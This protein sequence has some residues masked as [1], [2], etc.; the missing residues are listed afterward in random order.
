MNWVFRK[1]G[2]FPTVKR[3]EYNGRIY[4][5]K[6]EAG[7]AR[8]LDFLKKAKEI[9][10]WIPQYKI[11][12][13][14]NGYHIANYYVDFLVINND[15]TEEFHETKGFATDVFKLKWKLCEALYGK[16]YKMVLIKQ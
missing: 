8:D 2:K 5:S 15:G 16:T 11:S 12:L 14:V 7:Y 1:S 4:A 9:K 3:K 10:D 13:D 6:F